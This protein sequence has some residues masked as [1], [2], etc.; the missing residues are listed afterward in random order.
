MF[1]K[2]AV[3]FLDNGQSFIQQYLNYGRLFMPV[4]SVFV[5]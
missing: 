5:Q 1:G 3:A 4:Y 2:S